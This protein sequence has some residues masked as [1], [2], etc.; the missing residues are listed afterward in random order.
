MG[1]AAA[2]G[3]IVAARFAMIVA[4]VAVAALHYSG[5]RSENADAA[6]G[7]ALFILVVAALSA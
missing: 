7:A 5:A 4:A 3:A 1:P 6:F 2:Q